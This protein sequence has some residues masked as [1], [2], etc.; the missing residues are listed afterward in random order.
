M[1]ETRT[2]RVDRTLLGQFLRG[3]LDTGGIVLDDLAVFA[4]RMPARYM[5]TIIPMLAFFVLPDLNAA[6]NDRTIE[7]LRTYG[8]LTPD[9]KSVLNMYRPVAVGS[10]DP[11]S[12]ADLNHLAYRA[13]PPIGFQSEGPPPAD[14]RFVDSIR[15]EVTIAMPNGVPAN[16]TLKMNS[17]VND[18]VIVDG[19]SNPV[20]YE[21][22]NAY[23][24]AYARVQAEKANLTDKPG[25][26]EKEK[27]RYGHTKV[28]HIE[29]K[30]TPVIVV[31]ESLK[32]TNFP[33]KGESVDYDQLPDSFKQAVAKAM[34]QVRKQ[35]EARP[36]SG[37]GKIP[38]R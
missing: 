1:V 11:A 15:S 13:D 16:A 10:L 27:Y 36:T 20:N 14:G 19:G 23:A 31:D 5:D 26:R 33:R 17:T 21:P 25:D 29:L 34:D 9:Q 32:E 30:F 38:P 4:S 22:L 3:S 24:L 18:A 6:V 7:L 37:A 2:L 8:R 28:L 12:I 35:A